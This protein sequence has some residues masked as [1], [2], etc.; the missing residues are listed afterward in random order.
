VS[1]GP[2]AAVHHVAI[3]VADLP[4]MERFY[5]EVL[6]LP[7]LRRWVRPEGTGDRSVWLELGGGAFLALETVAAEAA[8]VDPAGRPGYYLVALRI[9]AATRA[10]WLARLAA[11]GVSVYRRTDYTL[12]LRDPEGNRVGLSHFPEPGP[13]P[14]GGEAG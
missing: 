11:A 3:Q 7:V 10:G 2:P 14:E 12:Y 4:R 9:G 8:P 13:K 5:R 1:S 6:G